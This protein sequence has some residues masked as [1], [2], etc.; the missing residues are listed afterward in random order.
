MLISK[1]AKKWNIPPEAIAELRLAMGTISTD[2][3]ASIGNSSEA[4]VQCTVRLE[5]SRK[6]LRLW[7]NNSGAVHTDD[8]RFIRYGLCNDSQKMNAMIKSHDLIGI[9][10]VKITHAHVGL[11]IGQF[12][13]REVKAEGWRWSGSDREIAQNR[14]SELV[15][16]MGGDAAFVTGE[17][18]L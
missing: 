17:G 1:W 6:G 7:R 11:L 13:S 18:S 5:A 10:P 2:P 3:V 9:R 8:N 12:V 14:F 16:S 15:I 4:I